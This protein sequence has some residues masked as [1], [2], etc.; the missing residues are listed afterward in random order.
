MLS[1]F[2]ADPIENDHKKL[3]IDGLTLVAPPRPFGDDP[4][5]PIRKINASWIAVIP[6]GFTPPSQPLVHY[7]SSRQWWGEKPEG[8]EVTI[9]LAKAA[10]LK[11]MLK[12]QVWSH[13]WWTGDY[14][15]DTEEDWRKW[16]QGYSRYIRQFAQMAQDLKVD[17]FCVG[18]EFKWS[19]VNRPKYW[20]K[21]IAEIRDLYDG[22]LTYAANWDNYQMVPFWDD[23]DYIGINAYFPLIE[24]HTPSIEALGH[25]W[26]RHVREMR[27]FYNKLNLPIIFTEYGYLSVDG[28]A[29]NTWELEEKINQ[30]SINQ[31]AQ[32]NAIDAL[33]RNFVDEPYWVGGFLW[34]WFPNMEGHEGYPQKDYTP[35]GKLAEEVLQRWFLGRAGKKHID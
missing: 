17:L 18:T 22:P 1:C 33:Y 34:K 28:C 12:P 7:N 2:S 5:A 32:A 21:L 16:E 3:V 11:V 20:K 23:L 9:E 26:Q 13:G 10:G 6:Y 31:K 15:F 19:V 29:H 25:A 24:D 27:S 14:Y 4:M 35:Q 8:I 30:L